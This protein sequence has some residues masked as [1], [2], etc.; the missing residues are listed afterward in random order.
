[1]MQTRSLE[2]HMVWDTRRL[3]LVISRPGTGRKP[4]YPITAEPLYSATTSAGQWQIEISLSFIKVEM[5]FESHRLIKM[6]C[7]FQIPPDCF[8]GACLSSF[9]SSQYRFCFQPDF[10]ILP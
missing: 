7:I 9:S 1:M 10:Q 4:W 5:T 2:D 8:C 6:G 3:L